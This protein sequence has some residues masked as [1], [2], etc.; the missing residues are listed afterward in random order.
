M[1]LGIG[2]DKPSF[3]SISTGVGWVKPVI[4]EL[5]EVLVWMVIDS[6]YIIFEFD[7]L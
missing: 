5:V 2:M 3:R 1:V 4:D 7:I 6:G